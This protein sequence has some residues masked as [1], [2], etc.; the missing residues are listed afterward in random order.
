MLYTWAPTG[1]LAWPSMVNLWMDPPH[2]MSKE[3][4]EGH[5]ETF[6]QDLLHST[7][8]LE[9]L[10]MN[11]ARW[12]CTVYDGINHFVSQSKALE[13]FTLNS[14]NWSLP[15]FQL[16]LVLADQ[17]RGFF[18]IRGP[19]GGGTWKNKGKDYVIIEIDRQP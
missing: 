6:T 3:E 14:A 12:R 19:L 10:A 2:R 4:M 8:R 18:P 16:S 9:T 7:P 1:S 11:C 15:L 5:A 17:D 13:V